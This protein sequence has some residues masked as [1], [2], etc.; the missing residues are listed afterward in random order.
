MSIRC[1]KYPWRIGIEEYLENDL[2]LLEVAS[3][4]CCVIDHKSSIQI[5]LPARTIYTGRELLTAYEL[6]DTDLKQQISQFAYSGETV[7]AAKDAYG[8]LRADKGEKSS[9]L[10]ILINESLRYIQRLNELIDEHMGKGAKGLTESMPWIEAFDKLA[11]TNWKGALARKPLIVELAEKHSFPLKEI[12]R[13]AKKVLRRKR[14][15]VKLSRAR[16]FDKA[17]LIR[18]AQLPGRNIAEKAGPRQRIPAVV[19]YET[20]DTLENRVVEHFCRLVEGE[21]LRTQQ[22]KRESLRGVWM[23]RAES[24]NSLCKHLRHGEDFNDIQKLK[25]PCVAPNFTLEQNTNYKSIW[26]GYKRLVRRLSEQEE[27]WAWARRVFLNRV[28]VFGAELLDSAFPQ[29]S[30]AHLPYYKHLRAR[31]NQVNGLWIDFDSLVGPRVFESINSGDFFTVYMLSPSDLDAGP[32]FLR[33]A[34]IFNAD[35]YFLSA[36]VDKFFICP[37][38]A[39]V[40]GDTHQATRDAA[41]DLCEVYAKKRAPIEGRK[42]SKLEF[43]KP[44]FLWADMCRPNGTIHQHEFREELLQAPIPVIN[45]PWCNPSDDLTGRLREELTQ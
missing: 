24:F 28:A 22:D 17:S 40:G 12:A 34:T 35:F 32:S 31:I 19:R 44:L 29:E 7:C 26:S 37:V 14:D 15:T 13:G 10:N 6:P 18:I 33:E 3:G 36:S 5:T 42:E 16:E 25:S 8:G 27:C 4:A 2:S 9:D 11:A 43:R 23:Q 41:S 20:T 38:Y 45:D 30:A 21:W 1:Y 39:F